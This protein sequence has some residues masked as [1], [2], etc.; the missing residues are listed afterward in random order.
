[1]DEPSDDLAYGVVILSASSEIVPV[2]PD[3]GSS[4]R[5]DA[6]SDV[7]GISAEGHK[8]DADRYTRR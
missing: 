5:R 6:P 3:Y 1:M 2:E 4:D 8:R 7:G